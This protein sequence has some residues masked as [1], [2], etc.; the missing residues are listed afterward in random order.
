M[1]AELYTSRRSGLIVVACGETPA[2]V[3]AGADALDALLRVA[4]PADVARA[5][6]ALGP[7]VGDT[8][9]EDLAP[10]GPLGA[11]RECALAGQPWDENAR[12]AAATIA[13]CGHG[14]VAEGGWAE[15]LSDWV[16]ARNL[17]TACC[18]LT[19]PG[20][21]GLEDRLATCGGA[22]GGGAARVLLARDPRRRNFR[23]AQGMLQER[24]ERLLLRVGRAAEEAGAEVAVEDG[25]AWLRVPVGGAGVADTVLGVAWEAFARVRPRATRE[26]GREARLAGADTL[27]RA[28]LALVD[29]PG[30]SYKLCVPCGRYFVQGPRKATFCSVNCRNAW[31]RAHS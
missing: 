9:A 25:L 10:G 14:D 24:D 6:S 27:S 15:P 31:H 1:G 3:A 12:P 4:R 18:A 16:C 23:V 8:G 5:A 30:R 19:A 13:A 26:P 29:H 17:L 11:T 28:T 20:A 22:V 21:E 7:L 2:A